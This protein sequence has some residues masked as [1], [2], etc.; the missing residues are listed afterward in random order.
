MASGQSTIPSSER[1]CWKPSPM[2]WESAGER[3]CNLDGIAAKL[4]KNEDVAETMGLL[5]SELQERRDHL[6]P[7][8]WKQFIA[9]NCRQHPL[10]ELLHQDPFSSRAFLK[11]RGYAGDAEMLDLIYAIED[12]ETLPALHQSS[13][14]GRRIHH[15]TANL[16]AARAVRSRRW[17]II[18]TLNELTARLARPHV[19]SLA[20][21]HLREARHC[22]TLRQG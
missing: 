10:L 17:I 15:A 7:E 21:G 3:T 12:G 9:M 22:S 11:P 18:D 6:S 5:F 13:E 2:F 20:C 16:A 1:S 19:L 8:S 14:L 4:Y